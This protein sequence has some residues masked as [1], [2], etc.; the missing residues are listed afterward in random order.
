MEDF[1][2]IIYL[3]AA[4]YFIFRS[5]KKNA[6]TPDTDFKPFE[7]GEP[8]SNSPSSKPITFE[9]LLREIQQSKTPTKPEIKSQPVKEVFTQPKYVDYD[10]DIP[11][12]AKDL[13]EVEYDYRNQDE[14]YETYEKA[15]REAFLKPSYDE[16]ANVNDTDVKFG[17]FK[18]YDVEKH[19]S[20]AE[21]LAKDLQNPENFK[22]AFILSEILNRR[23]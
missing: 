2:W 4:L 9:D 6:P 10:D 23:Y 20:L 13:E 5:R 12:E 19:P 14:I 18:E 17:H 8:P 16:T 7:S 15:K 1:K 11:E 21:N 22:K 3:I